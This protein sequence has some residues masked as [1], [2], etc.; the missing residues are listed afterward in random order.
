M[1]A[2]FG[3]FRVAVCFH[4]LRGCPPR[5]SLYRPL[6]T[7]TLNMSDEVTKAQ[8][9]VDSGDTIFGKM[10]RGDIPVKFIH[11]DDKCVAFDDISPQAPTH[12]LVIPRKPIP[13]MS[14]ATSDDESLIS[15]L[16]F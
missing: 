16:F 2:V 15:S 11:E 6:Y 1:S 8:S 14:K 10:L 13:M 5:L 7:T 3:S 4:S 9:A 12:F